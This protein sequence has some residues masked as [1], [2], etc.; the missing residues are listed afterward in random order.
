MPNPALLAE[1]IVAW[2]LV[3]TGVEDALALSLRTRQG[4]EFGFVLTAPDAEALRAALE[5][6]AG[7][8]RAGRERSEL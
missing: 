3:P 5:E 7:R 8:R 4:D 1:E 6:A 2:D